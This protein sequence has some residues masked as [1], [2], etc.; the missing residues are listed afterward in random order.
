MPMSPD[1]P[2]L[3]RGWSFP[4]TFSKGGREVETV[5]GAEDVAQ[6][7][8]II[9]ATEPGERPMREDFGASLFR[10]VFAEI[11]QTLLTELRGAIYDAMI[12]WE[13]RIAIQGL[14][15][16]E[17]GDEAGL[18]TISLSYTLRGANSRYNLVFPFYLREASG[19]AA[20]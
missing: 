2:F 3:G 14:E 19:A 17:S 12:A 11:S 9:F 7:L 16:V 1:A 5:A 6:S 10:H 4:P 20:R 18:L 8:Q 13:P 15:I